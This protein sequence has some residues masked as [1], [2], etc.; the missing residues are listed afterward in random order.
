MAKR[1]NELTTHHI[2]P[3]SRKGKNTE[4][5]IKRVPDKQHAAY[6]SLFANLTPDEVIEYLKQIWFNPN[7]KFIMPLE[8]LQRK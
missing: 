4:A 8:W 3:T 6:H 1:S 7:N 5:N 2:L